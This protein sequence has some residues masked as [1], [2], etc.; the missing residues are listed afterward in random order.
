MNDFL[1]E[2]LYEFQ[3]R[4]YMAEFLW[5]SMWIYIWIPMLPLYKQKLHM[6]L[7]YAIYDLIFELVWI[8]RLFLFENL[9]MNL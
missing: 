4:I 5:I 2:C 6:N 7:C 3:K 8:S 9:F 1:H